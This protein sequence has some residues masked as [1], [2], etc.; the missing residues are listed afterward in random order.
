MIGMN[1]SNLPISKHR[2]AETASKR[3]SVV[4]VCCKPSGSDALFAVSY[5]NNTSPH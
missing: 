2:A 1:S 4:N 5:F 3:P